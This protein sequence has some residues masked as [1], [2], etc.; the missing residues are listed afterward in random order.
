MNH[1]NILITGASSGFGQLMAIAL[2]D[3]GY[4]VWASMRN[5]EGKNSA[6]AEELRNNIQTGSG[7]L[8][9]ME[10]DVTNTLSVKKAIDR[11]RETDGRLDVIVNN[12]GVGSKALLEDFTEEMLNNLF[13]VNVYGVFRV[14]KA[15]LPM[16]KDQK[17]GLV[18]NISSGLGRYCLPT[19]TYYNAS[20]WALEALAQ[21]WR[22]EFA[23]L[24]IDCVLVEPGAF[25]TT[26]FKGNMEAFSVDA[27]SKA[28]EYGNLFK[29]HSNFEAMVAQ[30]IKEGTVNNPQMVSDAVV[31]LI[32]TPK[33]DRP[34]RTVVDA[35]SKQM[36]DPYNKMLD[37]IQ[38][39]L[40][41]NFGIGELTQ[42]KM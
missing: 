21:S 32:E 17:D 2:V 34:F 20:K 25:P 38:Q 33:G 5:L 30:Q 28:A 10:L 13:D 14:T 29:M 7:T 39:N 42:P 11:I 40:L 16:M 19:F 4:K 12:A 18:I 6:K 35:M 24:G 37:D 22:Y 1:K 3:K 36:L 27:S 31:K 26:G 41:N 23:P 8:E 15:A 9:L